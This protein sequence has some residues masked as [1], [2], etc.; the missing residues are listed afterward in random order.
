MIER[1]KIEN[2]RCFKSF[3]T[4]LFPITLISGENN[5]GKSTILESIFLLHSYSAPDFF[6]K[7]HFC[8]GI[9]SVNSAP[10]F[11]WEP[12]FHNMNTSQSLD[13]STFGESGEKKISLT[14]DDSNV[15]VAPR[16]SSFNYS[17]KYIFEAPGH[18]ES[19][20]YSIL[21]NGILRDS[22]GSKPYEG[23]PSTQYCGPNPSGGADLTIEQFG[24]AEL[25]GK[26]ETLVETL[27]LLD[28]RI[29]N[30]NTIVMGG[31]ASIY[32]TIT[33]GT[34][35]PLRNMG[36]GMNKLLSV[37]LAILANPGGAILIDEAENGLHYSFYGKYWALICKLAKESGCQVIATTHSYECIAGALE[38]AKK[39]NSEKS[40]GYIRLARMGEEISPKIFTD[41]KLAFALESEMEVR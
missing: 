38:G 19:G 34:K 32:A 15:S 35:F 22:A 1:L 6:L 12:L 14:Q 13:I 37:L 16:G 17:L 2:L 20:F 8:R 23:L 5:S 29:E 10:Q 30:L 9:V 3:E 26:K 4:E 31:V 25:A 21:P 41:E 39:T 24:R 33:G 18:S 40:F 36:D 28:E 27:R 7:I 11:L